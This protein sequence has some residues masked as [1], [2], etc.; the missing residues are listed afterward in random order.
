MEV[1][2]VVV[3][4]VVTSLKQRLVDR[5]LRIQ[6]TRGEQESLRRIVGVDDLYFGR[7]P[8]MPTVLPAPPCENEPAVTWM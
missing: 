6:E 8:L 5:F 2:L 4:R 1:A 3:V 7:P